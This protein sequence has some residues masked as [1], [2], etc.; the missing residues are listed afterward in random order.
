MN[1]LI[2]GGDNI[3]SF[4]RLLGEAGYQGFRHWSGR[5]AGD[6]H[7]SIPYDTQL[8][9]LVIDQVNHG[10]AAKIREQA[11]A[12]ALPIIYSPRSKSR[13][14]QQLARLPSDKRPALNH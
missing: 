7:Q 3:T 8:I 11:D 10:I 1:V 14:F 6:H 2:V 12:L 9:L 4:T 5:K 13:L